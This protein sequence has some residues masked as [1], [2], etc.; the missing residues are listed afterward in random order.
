MDIVSEFIIME[1]CP[2]M[3]TT[4]SIQILTATDVESQAGGGGT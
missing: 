3:D 2:H 4:I 1:H